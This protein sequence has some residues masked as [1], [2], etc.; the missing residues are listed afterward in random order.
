[1]KI[2]A[3]ITLVVLVGP[4]PVAADV[5]VVASN[6][7]N[8]VTLLDPADLAPVARFPTGVGPHEIAVSPDQRYAYV[9]D[10][11]TGPS[12]KPG[13]TVT[14]V[15][16]ARR[17][18]K[19]TYDLGAGSIPHDLALNRD[20]SILWAACAPERSVHEIDTDDG[21]PVRKWKTG[22][23]GGWMLAASPS[24]AKLYVAH[25]EGG[26]VSV[27]DRERERVSFI[28]TRP[29]EMGIAVSPDGAE[30]WAANVE[31][32]GVTVIDARTDRVLARFASGG[33]A[34]LRVKFTP[35][36]KRVLI[37][38]RASR[39][40][41][42]FDRARRAPIQTIRLPVQP[43]ILTLSGDGRRAFLTSPDRSMAMAV[44]LRSGRVTDLVPTGKTPDGIAWA[45]TPG[46][47]R[48]RVAFTINE[49]DLIP[50][51]IAHDPVTRTFFVSSTY[52]RKIVAVGPDGAAR[53]FTTEAQDGLMGVVGM[54]V[55]SR[56][57]LL[58]AASGDAGRNMPMKG[59][60]PSGEGSSGLFQY[61]LRTRKLVRKFLLGGG[62]E[63]HFLND[64]VVDARGDVYVTD[65]LGGAIYRVRAGSKRLEKFVERLPWPNGIAISGDQRALF[66][67]GRGAYRGIDIATRRIRELPSAVP[68]GS[69][70]GLAFH[71][72]ALVAV[73]P[74]EQGRVI[75]RYF[76]SPAGD[77]ITRSQVLVADH[78]EHSQPTTGVVVDGA[79]HY[80]A[81]SQL[82][83]FR[84]IFRADGSFPLLP[85]R[86]VVVL[87]VGL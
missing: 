74:W 35:D 11:G 47:F 29:G 76:L 37:A 68:V 79:L 71:R 49:P 66:V 57:R 80:I 77:R 65:S 40:L 67:A 85:L 17:E 18:V 62:R 32:G 43:K 42:V 26:G 38:H 16:L 21:S 59:M 30:V 20:G 82:Q 7:E 1:M 50:E 63:K 75:E 31:T 25:L 51:G 33:K 72:G 12:G 78:P 70:D 60:K 22:V 4:R 55:D 46:P 53:D 34:P 36:G 52:R 27:I 44:D 14:V 28:R 61:D 45:G 48:G 10:A 87:E 5:L 9:A 64:L 56:R 6:G 84:S 69:A 19:A 54:K 23:D 2:A 73:Q 58:W 15:D 8:T 13:R 39:T 86:P 83:L 24:G 81:N 41:V 3:I